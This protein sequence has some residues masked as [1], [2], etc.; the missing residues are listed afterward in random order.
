MLRFLLSF[1]LALCLEGQAWA[2]TEARVQRHQGTQCVCITSCHAERSMVRCTCGCATSLSSAW[3]ES[4]PR[5]ASL[6]SRL[7]TSHEN[8]KCVNARHMQCTSVGY[9]SSLKYQERALWPRLA[10]AD[11]LQAMCRLRCYLHSAPWVVQCGELERCWTAL[12]RMFK[13]TLL[14]WR[15]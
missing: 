4:R 14:Q 3:G 6:P 2:C 5:T 15:S 8:R 12:E 1:A 9:C 10:T 11:L 13:G 7:S